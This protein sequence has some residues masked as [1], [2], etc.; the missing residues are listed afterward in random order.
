[1]ENAKMTLFQ[2][3]G[4]NKNKAFR[5]LKYVF[6]KMWK[7]IFYHSFTGSFP[8]FSTDLKNKLFHT[9]TKSDIYV[10]NGQIKKILKNPTD[11]FSTFG[12][13]FYTGFST[14]DHKFS[15]VRNSL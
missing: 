9:K 8:H 12:Q 13:H 15:T 6:E 7:K 3:S 1:V 5:L 10:S 2:D 14:K 4:S 11:G